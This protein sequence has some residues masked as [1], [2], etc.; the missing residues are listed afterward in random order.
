MSVW[1]DEEQNRIIVDFQKQEL[2]FV[3]DMDVRQTVST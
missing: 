3:Q 2:S 1:N